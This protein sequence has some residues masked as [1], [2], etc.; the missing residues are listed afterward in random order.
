[1]QPISRITTLTILL[2]VSISL[3]SQGDVEVDGKV[4]VNR[5][6]TA[7]K[8]ALNTIYGNTM[9]IA[10]GSIDENGAITS[11]YG[12]GAV[13][14]TGTGVYSITIDLPT[15]PNNPVVIITP[16]S[17]PTPEAVGYEAVSSSVF[18]VRIVALDGTPRNSAF[19][20]VVFGDSQ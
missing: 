6:L 18:N 11:S 5:I 3:F 8:P 2:F 1:M 15:T 16:F 7:T 4:K 19:S 9:P 17:A 12:I 20:F 13:S 10:Y 14:R